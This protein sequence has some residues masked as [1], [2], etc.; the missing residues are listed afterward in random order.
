V[1]DLAGDLVDD[2]D[3]MWMPTIPARGGAD[4]A[5]RQ[6]DLELLRRSQPR[7]AARW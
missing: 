6:N 4:R 2:L 5:D 3:L 1:A 7:R